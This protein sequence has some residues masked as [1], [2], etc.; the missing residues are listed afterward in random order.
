MAMSSLTGDLGVL[1]GMLA[2]LAFAL[3]SA[4]HINQ[5]RKARHR[6][7]KATARLLNWK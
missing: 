4:L 2:L 3:L 7:R 6:M 1:V 5:G